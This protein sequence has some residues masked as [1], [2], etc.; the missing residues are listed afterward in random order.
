MGEYIDDGMDVLDVYNKA[1][2]AVE[3]AKGHVAFRA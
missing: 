2:R 1:N 3:L